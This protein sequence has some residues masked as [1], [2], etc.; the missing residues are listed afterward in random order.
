MLSRLQS[1][2]FH[3]P[4]ASSKTTFASSTPKSNPN[5]NIPPPPPNPSKADNKKKNLQTQL[6]PEVEEPANKKIWVRSLPL[7]DLRLNDLSVETKSLLKREVLD[8]GP[9]PSQTESCIF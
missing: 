4:L 7:T 2:Q 6:P 1:H 3:P 5:S 9:S 8:G